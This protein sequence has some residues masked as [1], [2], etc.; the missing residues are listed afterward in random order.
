MYFLSLAL[1]LFVGIFCA[2]DLPVEDGIF[3]LSDATFPEFIAENEFS[4][5]EFYAPW[6]GHC[7]QLAPVFV[8]VAKTLKSNG[9]SVPLAKVDCTQQKLICNDVQGYP[10]LK[11]FSRTGKIT[12]YDG[13]RSQEALVAYLTKKTGPAST[14]LTTAEEVASFLE[15]TNQRVIAYIDE[16][17]ADY[18][19]WKAV[20]SN[21]AVELFS[22]AHAD[23][24]LA[25]SKSRAVELFAKGKDTLTL[26]PEVYESA[27]ILDWISEHGFPLVETLSQ[28]AW[29]RAL[30]HPTSKFLACVFYDKTGEA[31]SSYVE[32]V[33]SQLKG[34]VIFTLS[35]STQILERWGGSGTVLPS[36]VVLDFNKAE[37]SLFTWD[38]SS[39]LELN[40]ETLKSFVDQSVAGTYKSNIK[41]E[42]IP[43]ANDEPVKTLVAKNF[44][45]VISDSSKTVI[46]VEFYAPW[47]GHCKKLAPVLDELGTHFKSNE[48]VVIAKMDATANTVRKDIS[49]TG[50]PTIYAFQ[51]GVHHPYSGGHDLEALTTFVQSFLKE[52]SANDNE[53]V[54]L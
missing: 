50:F 17:S 34:K 27:A 13:E 19:A 51:N 26:T 54:E 48:G 31:P 15:G 28:E 43:E 45:E 2:S 16:E 49:V 30:T 14:R 46:L 3:V 47:C 4:F 32:E 21:Q 40:A 44:E 22:F 36:A 52:G 8:E 20:A 35:D 11:L 23:T 9:V 6:C 5:I 10:T 37:P 38:E 7:K 42:P 25:G 29:N 33:A 53:N 24:S 18:E 12:D 39:G 1:C 41:S